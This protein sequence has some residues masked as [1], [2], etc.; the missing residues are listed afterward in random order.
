AKVS[1]FRAAATARGSASAS[2]KVISCTTSGESK[3]GSPC[4]TYQPF[5]SLEASC[6]G[7]GAGQT[8]SISSGIS[9]SSF[10]VVGMGGGDVVLLRRV[11]GEVI[12]FDRLRQRRAPDELPVALP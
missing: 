5:G 11:R 6:A 9:P 1:S 12:E 3:C 10:A 2:R 7:R 4:G 8:S